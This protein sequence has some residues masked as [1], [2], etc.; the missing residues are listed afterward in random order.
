MFNMNLVYVN[1]K[2]FDAE[3]FVVAI[4]DVLHITHAAIAT[5]SKPFIL[6]LDYI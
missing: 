4:V 2:W 3:G 5:V 6:I 1:G